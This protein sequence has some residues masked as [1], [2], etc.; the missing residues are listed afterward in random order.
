M[1]PLDMW[2]E[3]ESSRIPVVSFPSVRRPGP[4]GEVKGTRVGARCTAASV[5]F[6]R[7]DP[8]ASP[9]VFH[10][11]SIWLTVMLAVWRY[12]AV[13]HPLRHREWCG[14]A[15]ALRAIALA[16][17]AS[18]LLCAP[19]FLASAVR[20]QPRGNHT[21][22]VVGPSDLSRARGELLQT[23]NFWLYAVLI[24]LLPCAL[25]TLLSLALVSALAGRRRRAAG[26][27]AGRRADRTTAMLLAVLL[28]F[29]A[30]EV[31]QVRKRR[32][33]GGSCGC[34]SLL[35]HYHALN[36]L[37]ILPY[38]MPLA[39]ARPL[40]CSFGSCWEKTC[41]HRHLVCNTRCSFQN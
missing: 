32:S 21:L 12:V 17:L 19:L 11:V 20:A 26:G 28:L 41:P 18:P 6:A 10:T 1:K 4:G 34:G 39:C 33:G 3:S 9:Q 23:A 7:S 16:Y 37:A 2:N 31:P 27:G 36:F 13:G 29:L 15:R 8:G 38:L 24:K 14:R 25:L 22:F 40:S 30:A 35:P 5:G